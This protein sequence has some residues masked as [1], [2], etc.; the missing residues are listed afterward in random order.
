MHA[1]PGEKGLPWHGGPLAQNPPSTAGVQFQS[2]VREL[3]SPVLHGPAKTKKKK[4][5]EEPSD[6]HR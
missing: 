6:E 4:E 2:L 1:K 3:R 5:E